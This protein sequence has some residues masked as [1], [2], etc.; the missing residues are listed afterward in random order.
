MKSGALI[1]RFA[2]L[3]LPVACGEAAEESPAASPA[4]AL[5]VVQAGRLAQTTELAFDRL[6]W[7][8]AEQFHRNLSEEMHAELMASLDLRAFER[9][10]AALYEEALTQEELD[11][12]ARHYADPDTQW[13]LDLQARLFDRSYEIGD[14]WGREAGE[15][16]GQRMAQLEAEGVPTLTAPPLPPDED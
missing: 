9:Q 7:D 4:S 11:R 5:E 16:I 13:A 3:L 12:L 15:R 2:L 10:L 1:P 6:I 8:L 14:A